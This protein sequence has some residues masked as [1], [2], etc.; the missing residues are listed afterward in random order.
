M[1]RSTQEN[2]QVSSLSNDSID[3]TNK[4]APKVEQ[5][6]EKTLEMSRL[7]ILKK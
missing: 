4:L 1:E 6:R 3:V 7:K 2:T 5:N